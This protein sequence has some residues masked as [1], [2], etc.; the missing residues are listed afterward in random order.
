MTSTGKIDEK[1]FGSIKNMN[2]SMNLRTLMDLST[3]K[4]I[5]IEKRFIQVIQLSLFH[6]ITVNRAFL[7]VI[8]NNLSLIKY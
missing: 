4:M 2:T 7:F 8:H 3:F 6:I 5:T 1:K